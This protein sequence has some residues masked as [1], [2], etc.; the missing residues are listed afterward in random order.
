MRTIIDSSELD[1]LQQ[2]VEH[3]ERRQPGPLS[4]TDAGQLGG[5]QETCRRAIDNF[6]LE[7]GLRLRATVLYSRA[8]EIKVDA[9]MAMVKG[10]M[11][12]LCRG[13]G[14]H[15]TRCLTC[16]QGKVTN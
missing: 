3:L 8:T 15:R 9:I 6:E 11:P 16:P 5:I 14:T 1:R 4:D 12:R 7:D 2:L 10:F 13:C